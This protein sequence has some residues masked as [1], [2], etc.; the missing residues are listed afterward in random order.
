MSLLEIKN[1]HAKSTA[2]RSSKDRS[3]GECR[4]GPLHHGAERLGQKHAG[5]GAGAARDLRGHRRRDTVR[6]QGPAGDEAGR[7]ACE[8]VFL[9]FQYPVEIPGIS[10][11]YFLRAALNA[12][13]K[14][15]GQDEMDAMD[16]LPFYT[17]KMKLLEMDES[18][19]NRSVN[20]GFSGGE[21]KRNE[22]LQMAVLEPKLAILDETDSGLDIDAMRIVANG[23]NAMRSP[24]RAIIVVTHYQRLLDYIVPDFVHVLVD[25]RIVQVGRQGTGA[26]AR[27]TGLRWSRDRGAVQLRLRFDGGYERVDDHTTAPELPGNVPA[28]AEAVASPS[29]RSP[30]CE[31]CARTRLPVSASWASLPSMTKTGAS[32]TLRPSPRLHSISPRFPKTKPMSHRGRHRAVQAGGS[33][34]AAC[35]CERTLCAE[36]FRACQRGTRACRFPA[37][38]KRC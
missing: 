25:G 30:G 2:T 23:V 29:R 1:L 10:N 22:I 5:A 16:F 15:H 3:D 33:G 28:V 11:T 21:K 27:R 24:D 13:R 14:Y 38:P 12:V 35:V 7:R 34:R 4:G 19:M 6:R 18:F 20:E 26:G 9:A 36:S 32:P 17:E 8:G 37:L 31:V